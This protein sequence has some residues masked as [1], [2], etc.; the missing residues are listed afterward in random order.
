M[1][2][3]LY[4]TTLLLSPVAAFALTASDYYALAPELETSLI[5]AYGLMYTICTG[6][7]LAFYFFG[8]N[9]S[10]PLRF[11]MGFLVMSLLNNSAVLINRVVGTNYEAFILLYA[12][13]DLCD[14]ATGLYLI[15]RD[16][17]WCDEPRDLEMPKGI[18]LKTMVSEVLRED[19]AIGKGFSTATSAE[20]GWRDRIDIFSGLLWVSDAPNIILPYFFALFIWFFCPSRSFF[21]R[22]GW[23]REQTPVTNTDKFQK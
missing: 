6:S 3:G 4:I 10:W 15:Y 1:R 14:P 19:G 20:R 16:S 17:I 8:W 11:L 21:E 2:K 12:D 18:E 13:N 9:A 23:I 5:G 22:K 7:I